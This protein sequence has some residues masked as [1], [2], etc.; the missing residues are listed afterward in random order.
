MRRRE[1]RFQRKIV[2]VLLAILAFIYL[3]N[4]SYLAKQEGADV[5]EFDVHITKDGQFAV[6]HDW[7]MDCRTNAEGVTGDYTM[8]ELKKLDIGYG[9]TADHG[10]TSNFAGKGSI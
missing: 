4:S 8:D 5:V 3:N 9:Y 1:K 7:T 2:I 10:K 6:F